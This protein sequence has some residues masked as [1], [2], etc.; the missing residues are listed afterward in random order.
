MQAL[1]RSDAG[2]GVEQAPARNGLS[3]RAIFSA[4]GTSHTWRPAARLTRQL[5]L[6]Q[7]RADLPRSRVALA[8]LGTTSHISEIKP[9]LSMSAMG[10]AVPIFVGRQCVSWSQRQA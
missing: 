9:S 1:Q 8:R 6:Y 10:R 2:A 3:T 4:L 5:N 7:L